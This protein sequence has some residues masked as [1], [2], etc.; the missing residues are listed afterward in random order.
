MAAP[1]SR[2]Q[3]LHMTHVAVPAKVATRPST[4]RLRGALAALTCA[5][6]VGAASVGMIAAT[7]GG[8][9]RDIRPAGKAA[10]AGR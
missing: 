4:R 6:L 2:W 5:A 3:P 8:A 1:V 9:D 7:D 10:P